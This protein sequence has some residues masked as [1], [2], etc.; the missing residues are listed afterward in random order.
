MLAILTTFDTLFL[1]YATSKSQ[2]HFHS[3]DQLGN[4]ELIFIRKLESDAEGGGMSYFVGMDLPFFFTSSV[5]SGKDLF[6]A[7]LN[8]SWK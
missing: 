6:L 1:Q 3:T 8:T 7:L 2:L 4:L 5:I